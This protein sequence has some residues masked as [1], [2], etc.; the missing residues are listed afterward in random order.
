MVRVLGK[1]KAFSRNQFARKFPG[2]T[3]KVDRAVRYH[4]SSLGGLRAMGMRALFWMSLALIWYAYAGYPLLLW[5]FARRRPVQK[6]PWLPSVSVVIAAHNE[7]VNLPRKLEA[8]RAVDYPQ[9][10]LQV[11]IVSDGSTDGTPALLSAS[12]PFVTPV[13]VPSPVGKAEALNRGVAQATGAVL[14]FLDA[15]QSLEPDAI[16]ELVSCLADPAVGAVSGELHL[17]TAEGLPSPDGLGI[18]WKLEKLTRRLESASGSVV[19]VTGAIYAMRRELYQPIPPGTLLDDVLIPMQVARQGKRVLFDGGAIACDR[20]FPNPGKEF[21]RK[22]RTLTGNYQLLRLAPWLLSTANPLLFR[23]VSHKLLRLVVPVLLLMLL[24]SSA[25]AAGLFY[26]AVFA[27]QVVFYSIALIG[28]AFP[29]A[30]QQRA[31]SVPY[32]F[33]MLNVA[34]ALAF[35]NF[36]GGRTRWA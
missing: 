23:L 35:Y 13:I 6:A 34:A 8:L 27:L 10:L 25:L 4:R 20:I 36:L 1:Y 33:T 7:E 22:V 12:Q 3:P 24:V 21:A 32:T 30:R 2:M 16:A 11:I 19:G 9:R 14:V 15:R 17:Q 18:Y 5:A 26:K 29:S 31:V 28:F